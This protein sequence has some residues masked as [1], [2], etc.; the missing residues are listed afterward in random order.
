MVQPEV[1]NE[2]IRPALSDKK[3]RAVFISTPKGL[4][5]FYELFLLGQDRKNNPDWES[6][7]FPTIS[8]PHIDPKEIEEL[9]KTTPERIFA[10]EF[11]A[12]FLTDS[13][14]VFRK[15][16]SCFTSSSLSIPKENESYTMGVDLARFSD[17][18]VFTVINSKGDIV[19]FDRFNSTAWEVQKLRILSVARN[20]NAMVIIDRTGIGQPIYEDLSNEQDLNIFGYNISG[21]A[22]KNRL[23]E[24]LILSIENQKLHWENS[25]ELLQ[26]TKELKF[27]SMERSK[28][29]KMIYNA[30]NG[31]NDDCVISLALAN[32]ANQEG[33]TSEW[34]IRDM[35]PLLNYQKDTFSDSMN[36]L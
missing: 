20:Y 11:E 9:R 26:L 27:Y 14:E 30:P 35:S 24:S 6:W 32:L 36:R 3:G 33:A 1:W 34:H 16:E 23:I 31:M 5:F 19:Y 10:Q 13:G 8:N 2:A 12:Q 7:K 4:N 29:G 18:T 25:G 28:S 15:I 22:E 17:F 21:N